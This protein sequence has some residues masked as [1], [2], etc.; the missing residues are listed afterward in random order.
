MAPN[1]LIRRARAEARLTQAQLADRLGISQAALSKLERPGSNPTV[2][3]LEK[4][5]RATGRELELRLAHARPSVDETLLRE[6]MR[7]S[8][9][10]RITA[11]ER[12]LREAEALA[13][14]GAR[15]RPAA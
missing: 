15:A 7:I 8:P 9:A 11:A 6:A 2:R 1:A 5:L 12:L 13:A 3:T 10:A 14:A 4:V